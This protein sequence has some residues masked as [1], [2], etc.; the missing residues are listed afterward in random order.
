MKQLSLN[1]P[2]QVND[3]QSGTSTSYDKVRVAIS[4]LDHGVSVD[5]Y[6]YASASDTTGPGGNVFRAV[7]EIPAG[8]MTGIDAMQTKGLEALSNVV[9]S[10]LAGTV[11]DL[12]S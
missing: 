5:W 4:I 11:E 8:V 2:F 7:A 1:T 3:P 12:P 9:G 10:H 6:L